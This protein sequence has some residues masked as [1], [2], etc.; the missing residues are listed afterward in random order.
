MEQ[1]TLP[2]RSLGKDVVRFEEA[3]M[4]RP[5][6][7]IS[8]LRIALFV[9]AC[10]ATLAA[11]APLCRNLPTPW[12]TFT[13]GAI[14]SA[15]ALLLS[16]LFTRWDGITLR[17]IG[18]AVGSRSMSRF[19]AGFSIG[20]ILV[21]LQASIVRAAGH[22]HWT[23][24][25]NP[26]SA[27]V[28]LALLSYLLLACREE[29]AFHGYP[30]RRLDALF[31]MIPAQLA[32]ALVF[33]LEHRLGGFTWANA[34][35]SGVGSLLFGMASLATEGLAVPIGLH[36][37]W[38]IGQWTIGEKQTSG[39]WVAVVDQDAARSVERAGM[40]GYLVVFGFATCAFWVWHR[41]STR[42]SIDR[43]PVRELIE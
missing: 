10:A 35:A 24:A 12:Q 8:T 33:A 26:D 30:L 41:R 2:L 19:A 3:V 20:L 36:A 15:I 18:A 6:R 13:I 31:G 7:S 5:L 37:A 17:D 42:R 14:T 38:N 28:I 21:A 9:I 11:A 43:S 29:L 32:I 16:I 25:T 40:I 39:L 27:S 4:N 23:R 22:I 1:S 34:V